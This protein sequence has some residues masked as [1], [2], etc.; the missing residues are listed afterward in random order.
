M[1]QA[2]KMA[3]FAFDAGE[4][5]VG[6]IIV[7]ENGKIIAFGYNQVEKQGCQL[8]HAEVLAIQEACKEKGD[9]RLEKCELYVTLEP[10]LMC[11]GLI[12]LSRIEKI[13]FGAR[14]HLFGVGLNLE[15]IPGFYKKN[16]NI[17]GGIEEEQ[18]AYLLKQ[19][20]K[21]ARRQKEKGRV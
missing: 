21:N 7:D 8:F 16:L 15:E 1:K 17:I 20:F 5:P 9:W 10:C 11:L 14:S 3:Q 13:V 6:A 12:K 19:F 18:S 4:V 2:L